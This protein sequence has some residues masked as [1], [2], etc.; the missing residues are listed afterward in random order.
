MIA[1]ESY[2]WALS[3]AQKACSGADSPAAVAVVATA[4]TGA[5]CGAMTRGFGARESKPTGLPSTFGAA[6]M[7]TAIA[8]RPLGF[9]L[10]PL[11]PEPHEQGTVVNLAALSD[12][13]EARPRA[14]LRG[15]ASR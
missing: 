2:F 7:G 15:G 8:F 12:S 9:G 11:L 10:R 3:S 6:V 14:R 4:A 1:C 13:S 5:T